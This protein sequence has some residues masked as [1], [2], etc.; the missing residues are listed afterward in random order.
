MF[1]GCSSLVFL[2]IMNFDTSKVTNMSGM[3]C[4]CRS[5]NDLC[6]PNYNFVTKN[7]LDISFMFYNC[8]SLKNIIF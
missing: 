7:A 8:R 4:G 2:N 3:F 5:L 6:F 1:H